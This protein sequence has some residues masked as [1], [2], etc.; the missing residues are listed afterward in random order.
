MKLLLE[1]FDQTLFRV[2]EV[3]SLS[4]RAKLAIKTFVKRI[5]AIFATNTSF[6]RII[7]NLNQYNMKYVPSNSALLEILFFAQRFPKI[8]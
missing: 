4:A 7:A 5:F 3:G 1:V 2:A 6:L 8:V